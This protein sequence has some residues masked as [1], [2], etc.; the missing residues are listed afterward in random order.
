VSGLAEQFDCASHVLFR[1]ENI[2][3]VVS[4]NGE[5][6]D[7]VSGEWLDEGQQDSSLRKQEW[8]FE[9]KAHPARTG[10]DIFWNVAGGADDGEFVDSARDRS[11]LAARGPG[12]D[13]RVRGEAEDGV[14]AAELAEFEL[15][16]ARS[17][18]FGGSGHECRDRIAIYRVAC[19]ENCGQE[20]QPAPAALGSTAE[21]AVST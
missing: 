2:V 9:L 15:R 20:P 18:E 6:G 21:A 16:R 10:R 14:G 12:G 4:A 7:A 5:D 13:R 3:G 1:D 17:V 11:E 19:G 8:A